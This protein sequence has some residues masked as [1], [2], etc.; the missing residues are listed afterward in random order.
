LHPLAYVVKPPQVS[1]RREDHGLFGPG[2]PTWAV[3]SHP[4]LVI[5]GGRAAIVQMFHPPTAAGVAQHS[6]YAGDFHGRLRRTAHYFATVALGD[7][8]SAIEASERLR[9]VHE[10]VTGIEPLT[11]RPYRAGDPTNQLWVHV[12]GWHS[13]LYSYERYGPGRL[14][15]QDEARYWSECGIASELQDLDPS[16]VPCSRAAVRDYFESMR[17]CLCVSEHAQA[18]MLSLLPP[19]VPWEL[20]PF[21]PLLPVL[22]AATVATIPRHMRRL[23]GFDQPAVVDAGV[24]PLTRITMAALTLP[25]LERLLAAL[26]PEAY[27]VARDALAGR[28]PLRNEVVSPTDA[29]RRLAQRRPNRHARATHPHDRRHAG[30]ERSPVS[31]RATSRS[32][33]RPPR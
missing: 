13:A 5:A 33:A 26:A 14:S 22:A 20:A 18:I 15:P 25:V 30:T 28:P 4:S 21:V 10:R 7:A 27:A 9:R 3:W 19:P 17:P 32:A 31:L 8:R 29:R 1:R 24:R 6:V 2:S 12:T 23:G 11:G 16:D